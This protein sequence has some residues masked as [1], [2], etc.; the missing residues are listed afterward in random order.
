LDASIFEVFGDLS[1]SPLFVFWMLPG[2]L[3]LEFGDLISRACSQMT[4]EQKGKVP[5][6]ESPGGTPSL[7]FGEALDAVLFESRGTVALCFREF[8]ESRVWTG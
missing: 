2:V 8:K 7:R 6:H 1:K 5:N 3:I 4:T